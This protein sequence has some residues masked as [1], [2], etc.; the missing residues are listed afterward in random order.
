MPR[1]A[2]PQWLAPLLTLLV[3]G[4]MLLPWSAALAGSLRFCD[5]PLTLTAAQQDTLLRFSALIKAEL[6]ASGQPLALVARSGLDLSRFQQRYSHAG[7]SLRAS[8]NAPWSVRQLYY[9]CEE[10]RPRLYDQGLAGFVAG[11]DDPLLGYVSVLLLP[12]E[13]AAALEPVA[14]DNAQALQL[15]GAAY[16]ANAY[17]FSVRYQ[18]CN[19][20]L[21]ELLALAWGAPVPGDGEPV[22]A[23]AQRWLQQQGYAA[24]RIEVA[25]RLWLGLAAFVPWLHSDDHPA[26][27]LQ[28][29]SLQVSLP[30]SIEAFVRDRLPGA[31]RIE[32]CHD[33]RQVVIHRGWAPIAE[34]CRPARDDQVVLLDP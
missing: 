28:R 21:A 26:E 20:W 10:G 14:A 8:A 17:P 12:P 4:L 29:L 33:G 24:T 27:D 30:G 32:F 16:S 25:N 9:A 18:N 22:R 15:L 31:Q 23:R 1:R 2:A 19:Q 3:P 34:G 6:E 13:A 5:Q 7:V 11:T